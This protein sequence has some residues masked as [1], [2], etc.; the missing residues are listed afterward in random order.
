MAELGRID[1]RRDAPADAR[2]REA[3]SADL[4]LSFERVPASPG[5]TDEMAAGLRIL[6]KWLLRRHR[7]ESGRPAGE[8]RIIDMP[9]T[10]RPE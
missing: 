5:Q 1:S 2:G 9:L 7:R 3:D 6:T 10:S 8:D 4:E